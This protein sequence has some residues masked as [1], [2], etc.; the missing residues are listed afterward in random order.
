[1]EPGATVKVRVSL[2]RPPFEAPARIMWCRQENGA[3]VMGA[4][5]IQQNDL[6][7]ARMVEQVCYIEHYRNEMRRSEGRDLTSEEAAL[8]WIDLYAA[9][10]PGFES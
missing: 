4:A 7:R 1:M 9:D 8:E 2:V 10:F 6:F 3:Y 5:F